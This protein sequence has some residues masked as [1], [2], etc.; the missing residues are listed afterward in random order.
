MPSRRA[1]TFPRSPDA[2]PPGGKQPHARARRAGRRLVLAPHA[3]ADRAA[4]AADAAV[5]RAHRLVGPLAPHG[6]GDGARAALSREGRARRRRRERDRNADL[7][8]RRHLRR[9]RPR[10]LRHDVRRDVPH[11]LGRRADSRRPPHPAVR[12]PAAALARVLRA[13][14]RRR[15]H[16]QADERRRGDRPARHRRRD[17]ARPEHAHAPRHGDHPLRPRL[18]ARARDAAR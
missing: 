4:L 12:P 9:R 16:Q 1:P 5:S 6:N 11:G 18:A 2:R 8:R 14:P 13:Q 3:P 7:H 17:D 10:E 15:D